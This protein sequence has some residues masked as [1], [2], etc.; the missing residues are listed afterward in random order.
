VPAPPGPPAAL[1]RP[2]YRFGEFVV[3][4][5]R[6]LLLRAGTEVPIIPRYFDLLV[7]LIERR[8][9]AVHRREIVDRVWADVVVSDGALS[10]AVRT[11]R[12]ALG[13]DPRESRYI[14]TVARHGY[15]FVFADLA[16]EDDGPEPG[17]GRAKA[18][19]RRM[20]GAPGAPVEAPGSAA[21]EADP[22]EPLLTVLLRAG[23]CRD[24]TDEERRDAAAQL[25][26][27]GTAEALRRLDA[28]PGH[29]EARA[30]LRDTRWDVAGA[31]SVPLLASEG[32]FSS[33][34]AVVRLRLQGA[35]RL[36]AGR[37]AGA[38]LG[39]AVAGAVA[40]LAGGLALLLVPDSGATASVP[41]ALALVG[42]A[43]GG[44]G[45]CGIGAALAAAEALAR[46][47]RGVALVLAGAAAG[48]ATGAIVHVAGWSLMQALFGGRFAGAGGWAEGLAVGA[49]AGAGYALSTSGLR[50]GGLAA[51]RHGA[52]ARAAL[53]AG[54]CCAAGGFAVALAG[55]HLVGAS[56]DVVAAGFD[57]SQVGLG[58]IARWLGEQELRP[59]TR[60][61]VSAFEGLMFG[62]GLVAGL[63]RRPRSRNRT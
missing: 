59:V 23:A 41:G 38:T 39:G 24:A 21:P 7:L 22:F 56:L 48:A 33:A 32:G 34:L 11:L 44:A 51:P 55:G 52:R 3:S 28:R 5:G 58:P 43:A 6:R 63:T 27:L 46:S 57:G 8:H 20:P 4:P 37:W 62:T 12:R 45:A 13:D 2:R 16:E 50:G 35:A 25:H 53:L 9:E 30:I 10:Q 54:A 18:P 26:A 49:A 42:A 47:G 29:P 60:A 36:V 17:D 1:P 19:P 14:R 15:R 61:A 40:G 31:G